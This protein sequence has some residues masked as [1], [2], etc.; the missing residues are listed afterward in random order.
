[1]TFTLETF[2]ENENLFPKVGETQLWEETKR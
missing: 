1:M 2:K